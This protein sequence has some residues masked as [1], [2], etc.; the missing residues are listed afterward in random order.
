MGRTGTLFAY[1][2]ESIAP[3]I[4]CVAKGLGA[5]YQPIGATICTDKIYSAIKDG[6]GFFQHGHTYIGHPLAAAAANAVLDVLLEDNILENV[7]GLGAHLE[8]SLY[9]ELGQH[10][11][12]GDIRGRG[13]FYGLEIVKDK[14]TKEPFHSSDN[15]A[16]RIKLI[17]KN[18]GLLC[19]PMSG[20][21]DGKMGDHVL[22]APPYIINED[23]IQSVTTLLAESIDEALGCIKE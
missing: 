10:S 18:R 17:A 19:Y 7:A 14:K 2:Q 6:S 21:A 5:G 4:V 16:R 13:L 1:E 22:L 3:D 11:H 9:T 12:V 8:Q 20:T 23:E 15:L